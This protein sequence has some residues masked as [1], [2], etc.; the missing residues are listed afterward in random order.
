M[1]ANEHGSIHSKHLLAAERITWYLEE[2]DNP[3]REWRRRVF[4]KMPN[5][6]AKPVANI[7]R[8]LY[9]SG[10]KQKAN[11]FLLDIE[12]QIR[13]GSFLIGSSNESLRDSARDRANACYR[14]SILPQKYTQNLEHLY[15]CLST[16]ALGFGIEPPAIKKNI[17]YQSAIA[18]LQDEQWWRRQL[19]I[20]H[21]RNMELVA[22]KSGLV[23]R[24]ASIYVSEEALNRR[25][26]QKSANK[27]FLEQ[28]SMEN[29]EGDEFTLQ[30]LMSRSVANPK[31]RRN[32]L[33]CRIAGFE[34]MAKE[35]GHAGLFLT[36][37]CPSRMHSRHSTTGHAN[38]NYDGTSPGEANKYLVKVWSRIRAKLKRMGINVYGFRVAEPQHDATPHW[39]LLLFT[40]P[41]NVSLIEAIFKHYALQDSSDEAGAEKHRFKTVAID[42]TKGTATGYIAKYISK[43]IDGE[44]I[45]TDLYGNEAASTAERVDA[46]AS[47][48]GI[49][50]FQQFGG[51]SVT[52]WRELR[53][54]VEMPDGILK[55]AFEAADN[56]D[57]K[58]FVEILGGHTIQKK[59]VPAK[60]EMIWDDNLGKYGEPKGNRI[61]GVSD[62]VNIVETRIHIWKMKEMPYSQEHT[63]PRA[64]G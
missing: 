9:L 23:H 33:M 5:R 27:I 64:A 59:D 8:D 29:E 43:N 45:D 21:N 32:E 4:S 49:R 61:F 42:W 50:Q 28:I 51:A 16:Y 7:Y 39:H 15:H 25:R 3:N 37:T 17:T 62:G 41:E 19:R 55:D 38:R 2:P 53:R 24:H 18:R 36:L 35:C 10:S 60:L 48:W 20:V 30:E 11:E 22:I 58:L 52:L 44:H 56:G 14:L 6:F 47:T 34:A 63:A 57:W 12:K 40:E 1:N 13:S 31:N 26:E 46:W 54:G